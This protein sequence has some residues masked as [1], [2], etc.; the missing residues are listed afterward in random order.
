MQHQTGE[1]TALYEL[2]QGNQLWLKKMKKIKIPSRNG[3]LNSEELIN[4]S[5]ADRETEVVIGIP[6][7]SI[8]L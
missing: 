8:N 4:S 7:K 6:A 2:L 5:G 3:W 1:H